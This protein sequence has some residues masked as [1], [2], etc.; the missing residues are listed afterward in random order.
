M[1][2]IKKGVNM[3]EWEDNMR[4]AM[5][6]DGVITEGGVL[7][8]S[9][10]SWKD[11]FRN[12]WTPSGLKLVNGPT[13]A[14]AFVGY[15]TNGDSFP[16]TRLDGSPLQEE[17][18]VYPAKTST[19]PFT[20]TYGSVPVTFTTFKDFASWTGTYWQL[21]VGLVQDTSETPIRVRTDESISGTAVTQKDVNSENKLAI[22]AL[23]ASGLFTKTSDG[24][25]HLDIKNRLGTDIINSDIYNV[26]FTEDNQTLTN[27]TIDADYNTITDLTTLNFKSGVISTVINADSTDEQLP[28]AKAAY[29][30]LEK[31]VPQ[32]TTLP[33]ASATYEN[34]IVQ[35][36]GVT[37][38]D[39]INGFF[40]KCVLE[41]SVYVWKNIEV[42][43]SGAGLQQYVT[44]P[45][46]YT[47]WE[48]KSWQYIGADTTDYHNG[49][50]YTKGTKQVPAE[51][52][53][54]VNYYSFS[55]STEIDAYCA[56]PRPTSFNKKELY[57]DSALTNMIGYVDGND[58]YGPDTEFPMAIGWVNSFNDHMKDADTWIPEE[59]I[60][61]IHNTDATAH[62]DI[63]SLITGN[64]LPLSGGTLTGTLYT[65]AGRG[66]CN[67]TNSSTLTISGGSHVGGGANLYLCGTDNFDGQFTLQA[68]GQHTTCNLEGHYDGTL[69]WN[70]KP[71]SLDEYEK[72]TTNFSHA[73]SAGYMDACRCGNICIVTYKDMG[74]N[75]TGGVE[76]VGT[77][78]LP[79]GWKMYNDSTTY[80]YGFI[81]GEVRNTSDSNGIKTWAAGWG[82]NKITLSMWATSAKS[83]YQGCG[84]IIIPLVRG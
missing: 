39:Y 48:G 73:H 81:S 33:T 16:T 26:V 12:A 71:V 79:T 10:L 35:F 54:T 74:M 62:Q 72:L 6:P 63:R 18:Y 47:G 22:N 31:K 40:Y 42:Q 83:I 58:V 51:D 17:D 27:K 14:G 9:T 84:Q 52:Y 56:Y 1:A 37:T 38:S 7:N 76:V 25:V 80:C 11:N 8:E 34:K 78:T 59:G 57:S 43:N 49:A 23:A 36:I 32:Y 2:I 30:E 68:L 70:E 67:T 3:K 29:T 60:T 45:T 28:T 69:T 46:D 15:V 13:P 53:V 66:L 4:K 19:F 75:Y 41:N 5:T 21:R 55:E 77:V 20:I 61:H 82:T 65:S 24:R 44:P 50:L 64:Y